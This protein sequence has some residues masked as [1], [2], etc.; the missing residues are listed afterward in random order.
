[1]VDR[2]H[3]SIDTAS[4]DD[5]TDHVD[6]ADRTEHVNADGRTD[7]DDRADDVDT[8]DRTDVDDRTDD[9]NPADDR[10]DVATDDLNGTCRRSDHHGCWRYRLRPRQL[11]YCHVVPTPLYREATGRR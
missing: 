6:P 8:D 11:E 1:M 5:R 3:T 2:A 9:V 10:T 4:A 7:I